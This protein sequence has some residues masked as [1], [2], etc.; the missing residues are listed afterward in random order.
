MIVKNMN[1]ENECKDPRDAH[2]ALVREQR[3][4]PHM[5]G[6]R[7]RDTQIDMDAFDE[8]LMADVS[9]DVREDNGEDDDAIDHQDSTDKNSCDIHLVCV[10]HKMEVCLVKSQQM[11]LPSQDHMLILLQMQKRLN[12]SSMPP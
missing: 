4:K 9:L 8:A 1:I 5:F 7:T 11:W 3:V 12:S 6:E 10:Q 2:A